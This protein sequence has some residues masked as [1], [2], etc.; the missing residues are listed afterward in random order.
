M[1]APAK[2][3]TLYGPHGQPFMDSTQQRINVRER[4]LAY[5]ERFNFDLTDGTTKMIALAFS[6]QD[7]CEALR[8]RIAAL[9][10]KRDGLRDALTAIEME[11]R[12]N[13][14][15]TFAEINE[16]ARA[17]LKGEK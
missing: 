5:A 8:E 17:A 3:T 6:W 2:P 12:H 7:E 4:M 14:Q 16:C 11:S 10:A 13:A 15:W 9:E 1:T